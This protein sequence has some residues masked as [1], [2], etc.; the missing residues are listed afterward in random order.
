M[1]HARYVISIPE[2]DNLGNQLAD[3]PHAAH[4]FLFHNHRIEGSYVERGK[5]GFW[6]DDPE[7]P[8]SH[9]ISVAEDTPYHDSA[10]KQLAQH[11]AQLANQWGVFVMKEGKNGPEPWMIT[12][13]N[14]R[15]GEPADIDALANPDAAVSDL[16]GPDP[17]PVSTR[18]ITQREGLLRPSLNKI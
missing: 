6:R 4:Q 17:H 12:N 3:I 2:K 5:R 11:V 10:F 8:M 16:M 7:E 9:L 18:Y 1:T 14:Y 13:K 15:P